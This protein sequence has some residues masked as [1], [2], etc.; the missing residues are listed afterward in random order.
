MK[1]V[2]KWV[3]IGFVGLFVL[4][5]VI[6]V[7]DDTED[8]KVV[9]QTVTDSGGGIANPPDADDSP[10]VEEED[11][12]E[13]PDPD[14]EYKLNC[15]YLLGDFGE[16][17][18]PSKGY[19]FVG[20]GTLRNTGNVGVR[21]RVTY[22]WQLLGQSPKTLKKTYKLLHGQGPREVDSTVPATS[23]EIDQHQ[24]ADGDCSAKATIIGVLDE[25]GNPS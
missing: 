8:A 2:L 21:V 23:D 9:T 18:D 15:A 22:K 16:S 1:M 11:P 6:G 20:G 14:A 25:D 3:G 17:G 7:T 13:P 12:P 10:L 5:L 19:R 24:R 4:G